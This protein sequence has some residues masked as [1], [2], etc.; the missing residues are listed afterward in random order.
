MRGLW[1]YR[2]TLVGETAGVGGEEGR[3]ESR[4][5]TPWAVN[6]IL[7]QYWV[8]PCIQIVQSLKLT[9]SLSLFLDIQL[10][11]D[12]LINILVARLDTT[13]S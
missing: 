7:Y 6:V 12:E 4:D 5:L 11:Q 13:T 2:L 9:L 3:L 1:I 8:F 10:I